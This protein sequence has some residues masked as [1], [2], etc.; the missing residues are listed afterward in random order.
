MKFNLSRLFSLA[1]ILTIGIP[2]VVWGEHL[3][4]FYVVTLVDNGPSE[5]GDG[6]T[7]DIDPLYF[8]NDN[9]SMYYKP[10]AAVEDYEPISKLESLPGINEYYKFLGFYTS[11]KGQGTQVIDADGNI[12]LQGISINEDMTLYTNYAQLYVL[13]LDKNGGSGGTDFLYR[14][15]SWANGDLCRV[16]TDYLGQTDSYHF[17]APVKE[18]YY[19]AGYK[20]SAGRLWIDSSGG[21]ADYAQ[22]N[23][24]KAPTSGFYLYAYWMQCGVGKYYEGGQCKDCPGATTS[25]LANLYSF[26]KYNNS[27]DVSSCGLMLDVSKSKCDTGTNVVF[28]WDEVHDK[29][30][31][32]DDDITLLPDDGA[33][34]VP[35]VASDALVDY[36]MVCDIANG[37]YIDNNGYCY[38]CPPKPSGEGASLYNFMEY[39]NGSGKGSCALRLNLSRSNCGVG[40]D[41]VYAYDESTNKYKV[42]K[43]VIVT[44]SHT[45]I[46]ANVEENV[47]QDY[48]KKCADNQYSVGG[49]CGWCTNGY[50]VHEGVCERCPAGYKCSA[51]VNA[52]NDETDKQRCEKNEYSEAGRAECSVCEAG[53]ST[54]HSGNLCEIVVDG[55]GV[56]C[57]SS[58]ACKA[59]T[60]HLR[61]SN[62]SGDNCYINFGDNV[63]IDSI[64]KSVIKERN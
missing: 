6:W 11:E 23:A 30:V 61:K 17:V 15:G 31:R 38:A 16:W 60:G 50:Y 34:F 20:D 35:D 45:G 32:D 55:F 36:C 63:K 21:I 3:E 5:E 29:Y 51:K 49:Y 2:G 40:T 12:I 54:A 53:F 44:Q 1:L 24:C 48:C 28:H 14:L 4:N 64:N 62:C 9:H 46:I 26:V 18:G 47:L 58:A 25:D 8:N 22:H 57:R 52:N 10:N 27:E 43:K 41:V 42:V 13:G 33:A 59:D 19:F 37:N 7:Q 39:N 56:G